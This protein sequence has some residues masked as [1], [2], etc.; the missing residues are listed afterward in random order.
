M[1]NTHVLSSKKNLL[2]NSLNKNRYFFLVYLVLPI[3]IAMVIP[4]VVL[5]LIYVYFFCHKEFLVNV[6]DIPEFHPT[7]KYTHVRL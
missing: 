2:I 1:E 6:I 3:P 7:L 4:L 5:V